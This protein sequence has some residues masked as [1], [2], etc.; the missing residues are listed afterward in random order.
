MPTWFDDLLGDFSKGIKDAGTN[1][2]DYFTSPEGVIG[3][4]SLGLGYLGAKSGK[5]ES[6]IEPVGY[7]GGIPALVVG[8]LLIRSMYL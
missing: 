2:V 5:M 6:K 7:Q 8:T 3:L 4:G 1:A